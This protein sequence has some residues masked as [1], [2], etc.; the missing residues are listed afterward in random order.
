LGLQHSDRNRL[1][2]AGGL[3]RSDREGVCGDLGNERLIAVDRVR[4]YAAVVRKY[5]RQL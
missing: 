5:G 4:V 2:A 3:Q 1:S